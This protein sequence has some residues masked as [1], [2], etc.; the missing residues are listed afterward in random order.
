VRS[1]KSL[2]SPLGARVTGAKDYVDSCVTAAGLVVGEWVVSAGKVVRQRV[3]LKVSVGPGAVSDR[4][5]ATAGTHVPLKQGGGRVVT[6]SP[7]SRPPG[8]P[9]WELPEP[10]GGFVRLGRFAVVPPQPQLSA[11]PPKAGLVTTVDDVFVRGADVIVVEQG[12]TLGGSPIAPPS[13]GTRV[14]LGALGSGV[15]SLSPL[16]SSVTAQP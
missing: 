13:G 16:A 4:S 3:A 10:P 8:P 1:A 2:A 12:E 11:G 15:T 9:F 5:F 14:D 6:L 7:T